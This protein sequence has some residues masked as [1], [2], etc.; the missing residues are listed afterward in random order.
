MKLEKKYPSEVYL[1]GKWLK[2]DEAYVSVFDRAFMFGDGVYEVTPFYKGKAF[3]LKEHLKRLQYSLDQIQ[4]TFDAFSLENLMYEALDRLNLNETDAA[5]YIQVSRGAAARSHF[6]PEKIETSILLYAFPVA[7][8]GFENKT[9]EVMATEDKR[10]HRCD[11]K[12]TA[13]LANVMANEE[14]IAAGFAENLLVRKGYFTEGSHSSLF[15]VKYG[16]LHTHPEGPEILSGVTR[17]EVINICADLN[18]KVVEK[19]VHIDELVEVDE[20]FVTGTT[21]QI[22]PISSITHK[23]K[24]VYTARKD[25]ITRKLQKVFIERTRK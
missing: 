7:L 21:T 3:K 23:N 8:E 11:I 16:V 19:A 20:I 12:S 18:I 25:S 22:I 1:N 14:A 6:I 9:W 13:L 15:F 24:K 4:V 5:V 2:P 17:A 10:W